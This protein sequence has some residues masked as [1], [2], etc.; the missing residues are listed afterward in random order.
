MVSKA[1]FLSIEV[2][3]SRT[4]PTDLA[5]KMFGEPGIALIGYVRGTSFDVYCC[6][7]KLSRAHAN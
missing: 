2:I 4:S 5:A 7:D 3:A 6:P 1:A